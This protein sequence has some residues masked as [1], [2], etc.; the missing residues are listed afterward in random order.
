MSKLKAANVKLSYKARQANGRYF[1]DITLKNTSGGI[2]FFNQLQFLNSKMSPIR[3][4]F[5]SDNFFSL[6]PGEKK[7]VTIETAEEKL[8][9]GAVLVLKGWNVTTQKYKLK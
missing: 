7:T 9:E 5:Y 2:A 1:V 4:S 8:T 6:V 3:P